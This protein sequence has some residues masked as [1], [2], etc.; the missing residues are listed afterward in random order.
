M[1]S[2]E[3]PWLFV[4]ILFDMSSFLLSVVSSTTFTERAK[5]SEIKSLHTNWFT[6]H[7][8]LNADVQL[9]LVLVSNVIG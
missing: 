6:N 8:N 1:D 3:P 4:S 9:R 5:N 7:F 2:L